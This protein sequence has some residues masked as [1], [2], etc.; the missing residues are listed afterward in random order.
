MAKSD[1]D[2]EILIV[3]LKILTGEYSCRAQNIAGT[4][5]RNISLSVFVQ[6]EI[7][8]SNDSYIWI[9]SENE[10]T[11]GLELSC[12]AV[13]NPKPQI[14]WF[15]LGTPVESLHDDVVIKG[16]SLFIPNVQVFPIFWPLK[17]D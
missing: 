5:M 11:E 8:I 9:Y 14:S 3:L 6:P 12:P 13:G 16:D 1:T 7:T 10:K 17:N 15:K 2:R 4:A